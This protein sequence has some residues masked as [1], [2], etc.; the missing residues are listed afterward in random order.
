MVDKE[1][2]TKKIVFTG[3]GSG[4]HTS[5]ASAILEGIRAKYPNATDQ[6]LYIGGKPTIDGKGDGKSLEEK[7]FAGTEVRFIAIRAGKL[8]RYFSWTSVKLLLGVL[9]GFLDARRELARF[10][11]DLVISTGGYVTV[12]VC[13]VAW[14]MK[15]PVYIHEQTAAVGLTNKIT[16]KFAT[17]VYTSFTQSARYFKPEKTLHVGNAVRASVFDTTGQGHIVD[18]VKKMQK[19]R[20]KKPIIL[21]TGGGQGSHIINLT[22]RQMLKYM[23]EDFQIIIQTGDNKDLKDYEILERERG[24]LDEVRRDAFYP[25]KYIPADQI[26]YVFANIDLHVGRSGANFVYE[27]AVLEIPS[28][29]IPI[30][31]VTHNE[32]YKNAKNLEDLGLA[33]IINE[34]ELSPEGLNREIRLM[35]ERIQGGKLSYDKDEVKRNFPTDAVERIVQDLGL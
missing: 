22:V 27:T 8:Q 16:G 19:Q 3:G 9:G 1:Q 31:W 5:A 34:G 15:I 25:V 18:A 6:I 24:K 32:Q 26:G 33:K 35:I 13:I 28:I 4:G 29:F 20:P 10:K 2:L 11:P 23:I 30:P 21:F 14:L 17:R 12:P 7:V